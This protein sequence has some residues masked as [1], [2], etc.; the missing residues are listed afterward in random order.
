M[1]GFFHEA[2]AQVNLWTLAQDKK[3]L[4]A[5][6]LPLAYPKHSAWVPIA[7]SYPSSAGGG[8]KAS[9]TLIFTVDSF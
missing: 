8:C 9:D 4:Q 2:P 7:S 5:E 3:Y 6:D 1:L